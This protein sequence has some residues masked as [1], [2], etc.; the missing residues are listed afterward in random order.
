MIKLYTDE[1]FEKAKYNEYLNIK[2]EDCGD[3]ISKEKRNIIYGL[4][5]YQGKQN[6][7]CKKCSYRR[8]SEK[9]N[10]QFICGFC[11]KQFIG[12]KSTNDVT[13]K[14]N[15][16]SKDCSI[17]HRNILNL[18]KRASINK[19]ISIG[20]HKYLD[21]AP[22]KINILK[23]Y[24]CKTCKY[25]FC[26]INKR[27]NKYCSVECRYALYRTHEYS[28]KMSKVLKGKTGGLRD[29]GG[30]SKMLLYTNWLGEEMKLNI[31]EIEVAKVMDNLNIKWYRN[32]NGFPYIDLDGN[33]RKYYPDFYVEDYNYYIEY[34]G[35]VTDV[36]THKMNEAKINNNLNLLI[37]YSNEKRYRDLGLNL[38][39]LKDNNEILYEYL[40]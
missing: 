11:D 39:Q 24:I 4:K 20:I 14:Y 10:I 34:K 9:F 2:C 18:E 6:E 23:G 40:R 16:C 15:Y 13:A 3:I 21:N 37:I 33:N 8:K 29:G 36:M 17:K 5:G 22:D 31:D 28:E 25:N 26:T 19:K 35:W 38:K 7:Y 27:K 30:Y 1:E 12:K 32:T